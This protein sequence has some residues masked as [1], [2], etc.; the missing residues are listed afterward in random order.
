MTNRSQLRSRSGTVIDAFQRAHESVAEADQG[1][2]DRRASVAG[3]PIPT[4]P[5]PSA[6]RAGIAS[7][8]RSCY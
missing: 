2:L 7:G 8:L 5:A 3:P 1:R 4:S 6:T